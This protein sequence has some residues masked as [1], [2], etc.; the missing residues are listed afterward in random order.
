MPSPKMT[1]AQS[2]GRF[3]EMYLSLD[4]SEQSECDAIMEAMPMTE[5]QAVT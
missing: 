1:A 5:K 2:V 4:E 3:I